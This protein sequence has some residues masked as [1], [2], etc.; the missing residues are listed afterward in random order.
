MRKEVPTVELEA[1][2]RAGAAVYELC[3]LA[4]TKRAELAAAGRHPWEAEPATASVLI[5]SWNARVHQ[6]LAS[7]LLDADY[8]EDPLTA[9]FVPPVTARQAWVFYEPVQHWLSAGRRA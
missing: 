7:E 2:R 6:T 4:E 3:L 5:C 9:G 8:R 1:F